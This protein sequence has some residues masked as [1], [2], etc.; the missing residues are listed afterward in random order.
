MSESVALLSQLPQLEKEALETL[1]APGAQPLLPMSWEQVG[2][3]VILPAWHAQVS[4]HSVLLAG[5]TLG[6]L[7]EWAAA[8]AG[9]GAR[10]PRP[11]SKVAVRDDQ[12]VVAGV[13][14]L[15]MAAG[16]ALAAQGWEVESLPGEPV[17][18]RRGEQALVPF[19][20]V[21][22]LAT[23]RMEA[24]AWYGQMHELG[25]V[26]AWLAVGP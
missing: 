12:L 10:L 7:P 5:A 4:E 24:A 11:A 1:R 15:A 8:A 2:E 17:T 14:L 16:V 26:N 9:L 25:L 23:G 6:N 13:R 20:I 18:F 19:Q 22:R 21:S 3:V